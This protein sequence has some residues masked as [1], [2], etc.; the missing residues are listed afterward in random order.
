MLALNNTKYQKWHKLP[1]SSFQKILV[2]GFFFCFVYLD[3]P[4]MITKHIFLFFLTVFF[5]SNLFFVW[6]LLWHYR[7]N[8]KYATFYL[9][10]AQNSYFFTRIFLSRLIKIG[11]KSMEKSSSRKIQPP[12]VD[13]RL[14]ATYCFGYHSINEEG[15]KL[16][17]QDS[18][19]KIQVYSE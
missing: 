10:W 1:S 17:R 19:D 11:K 16:Q 4:F 6:H 13:S 5:T 8:R 12:K 9:G 14:Q 15:K 3:Q 2:Q 18:Y 7:H